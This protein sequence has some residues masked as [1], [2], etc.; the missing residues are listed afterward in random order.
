MFHIIF[1]CK[2]SIKYTQNKPNNY[3]NPPISYKML[4]YFI[5]WRND[6]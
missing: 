3:V 6:E 2:D 4:L 1:L 5:F